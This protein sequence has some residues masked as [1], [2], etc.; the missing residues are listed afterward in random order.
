MNLGVPPGGI[1]TEE[2]FLVEVLGYRR[3][4]LTDQQRDMGVKWFEGSDGSQIHLSEDPDHVPPR[5]AH[6]AVECTDEELP[7]VERR[8]EV[9]GVSV[10]QITNPDIRKFLVFKDPAG[11]RWEI[12]SSS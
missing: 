4:T 6:V 2:N 1:E 9:A 11:N 12:R 7:D 10:R 3:M 8:L 5:R